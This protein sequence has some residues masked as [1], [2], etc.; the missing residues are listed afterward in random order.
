MI[1]N[2][3]QGIVK[4]QRTGG[5][6]DFNY[7]QVL[8]NSVSVQATN[9]P[10]VL[11]IAHGNSNYLV[12]IE[13]TVNDA[14]PLFGTASFPS[15]VNYWLYVDINP[16][17]GVLRYGR[18]TKEPTFGVT[19]PT[20]PTIDQ[21]WFDVRNNK[22]F[23][24]NG[25]MWVERIRVFVGKLTQTSTI[26][27]YPLGSQ[28]G[29]Q[30][31]VRAGKIIHDRSGRPVVKSTGELF[32]T[33]DDI[34]VN[35]VV[36][37]PNALETRL[38]PVQAAEVIPAFSVVA[39]SA[40]GVVRLAAYEDTTTKILAFAQ[41]SIPTNGSGL[42]TAQGIITN[43][44]WNWPT[45]NAPLWVDASG[46]LTLVDPAVT[47]PTRDTEPP[48]AHVLNTTQIKFTQAPAGIPGA[49]GPTGPAGVDGIDGAVG[50]TGPQGTAG[51]VGPT[52]PQG[53][54][55]VDGEVGPTGPQG[56]DSTLAGPSGPAGAD[57]TVAGPTGPQGAVGPTGPQG[58]AGVDGAVGPTGP[59]GVQGIQGIDGAVGPTGPQGV[60][61][62]AGADGAA[63]VAGPTGP[64]GAVGPTGPG[65]GAT[66]P[67]GA[68]GATGPTGPQGV[69]G[70]QGIA[71][72]DGAVGPTGPQGPQ[73][74]AGVDG[75]V[76]P[77]GPQGV[78]GP[79]GADS[80]VPGPTGPQGI[81]GA[82]GPTGP[83]G[84]DST[85]AGPTGPA[86]ADGAAG[87]AGPT[88]PTGP[89]G[90]DSTVAGPA[91][92]VGPTG[93]QG[94]AGADGATGPTGPQGVAGPAGADGAAGA[95]GPT[96]PQGIAGVG[97]P[98][99]GTTAQ[100]LAK[101]SGSDYDVQWVTPSAGAGGS[102]IDRVMTV[103]NGIAD[104]TV[105][106]VGFGTQSDL[107]AVVASAA[108][109][110]LQIT[111]VPSTLK[112][113][114]INISYPA[115]YNTTTAF[116]IQ[117]PEPFGRT[118][119]TGMAIPLMLMFNDGT[120]SVMQATTTTNYSVTGGVVQMQKT[121]LVANTPFRF[122]VEVI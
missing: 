19:R 117:Y 15:G 48:V 110:T 51:A 80:V 31:R 49:A 69:A 21:H 62:P 84:A 64:Q 26:D 107:D 4:G 61:G 96:G 100:V 95:V 66:G 45:V 46:Q 47:N 20:N 113:Q 99:G 56:A 102:F 77:T 41:E 83:A 6:G 121:G 9:S 92:A 23:A 63:G 86:G 79:A 65:V 43:P 5:N 40:F 27:F 44:S 38:L 115:G 29:A 52:G 50:P 60:A 93:P 70:P 12:T 90:A 34:V 108:G 10:L 2:F 71:G 35:G 120:P 111:N 74:T 13:Q 24:W 101:T 78:A 98:T 105:V 122:R 67:A 72:V 14:W 118:T 22:M 109:S 7:L 17:T 76:G 1:L 106:L 53:V 57:S 68:D 91:G 16:V 87:A 58:V 85:V 112:L 103:N 119:A 25:A 11:N 32:T 39:F 88:G 97:V 94:V 33:E 89:A 30:A 81:A 3:R 36:E 114:K 116:A 104:A 54:A 82:V 42:V 28:V 73:G 8:P 75:A 18:I 37:A 55:G 59:Q